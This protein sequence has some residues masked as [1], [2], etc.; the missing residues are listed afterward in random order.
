MLGD[1]RPVAGFQ[2]PPARLRP[3]VDLDAA[4]PRDGGIRRDA[5]ELEPVA[6]RLGAEPR[7]DLLVRRILTGVIPLFSTEIHRLNSTWSPV[8][9]TS[10][11]PLSTATTGGASDGSQGDA[12]RNWFVSPYED[13]G[14]WSRRP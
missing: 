5:R 12:Y 3:V 4:G 6:G 8:S 11:M 10:S 1:P 13:F 2:R 14:R 9:S 7:V